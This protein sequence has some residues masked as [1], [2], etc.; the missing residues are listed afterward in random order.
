M[1][2]FWLSTTN[3]LLQKE[4]R[5]SS[6]TLDKGF[7][8]APIVSEGTTFV[9]FAEVCMDVHHLHENCDLSHLMLQ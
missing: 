8:F 1:E 7:H 4:F 2:A 5:Q 9:D 6:G 3:A